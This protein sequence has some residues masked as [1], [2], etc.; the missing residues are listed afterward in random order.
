MV[1]P[2]SFFGM[3]IGHSTNPWPNVHF[4]A[5]RLWDS[6]NHWN[7]F[8]PTA[9]NF[10]FS[11]IDAWLA[12][13]KRHGISE[14]IYTFGVTPQWASSNPTD[15]NCDF[16]IAGGC[17]LPPDLKPN[18]TGT[19]A[20]MKAAIRALAAHVNQATYLQTHAHVKYWEPWNEWYRNPYMPS[21]ANCDT[22]AGR[23]SIHATY[24]QMVRWTEDM[25]CTITGT[26]SVNGAA[27]KATPL[28]SSAVI[29]TPSTTA[30]NGAVMQNFLYCNANP[31][32][33][34]LCTTGSRGSAAVGVINVHSYQ[35]GGIGS[36]IGLLNEVNTYKRLLSAADKSKPIWSDEGGWGKNGN[37]PDP[38]EQ[39]AFVAEYYLYGLQAGLSQ[40]YWYEWDNGYKSH[41]PRGNAWGTLWTKPGGT[42]RAG[43]AYDQVYK[44][45]VDATPASPF[46]TQSGHLWMCT[47]TR[48]GGYQAA[49]VWDTSQ[50]CSSG[51]CTVAKQIV[52]AQYL[53]YKDL[54]GKAH[55]ISDHI[56]PVGLRPILLENQ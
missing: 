45:L 32:A 55:V 24:A 10:D 31:P 51:T 9:G 12:L 6:N 46:C 43:A 47:L 30:G 42:T 7:Q 39:A 17:Y 28:D 37:L 11:Q 16:H 13:L 25:R 26:G 56:V 21:Y 1:I 19:N 15:V 44:W 50:S 53:Y 23:C 20:T 54:G 34:A 22:G 36:A 35:T 49:A 33:A 18:G 29:I 48:S 41:P 52:G 14:A 40:A 8:E 2:P 5:F 4:G 3:H 27:C 38:D